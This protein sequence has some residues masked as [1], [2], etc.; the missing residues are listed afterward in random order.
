MHSTPYAVVSST[1][2]PRPVGKREL[3]S[4]SRSMEAAA[5]AE[6]AAV[7]MAALQDQRFLTV[8]TRQVYRRLADA[9]AR[10]TLYA[11][12][13]QSWIAPGVRGVSLDDEDPLVDEWVVVV[14]SRRPVVMAAADLGRPY[15]DD[16]LR[17]FSY[18]V[19]HDPDVVA[20]CAA[21]LGPEPGAQPA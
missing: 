21:L 10:V 7:V 3:I 8:R 1:V 18:A 14:P 20:R 4:I 19:S 9:G 16:L 11:R 6:P 17:G 12:G 13:L 15:E 5:L 2:A